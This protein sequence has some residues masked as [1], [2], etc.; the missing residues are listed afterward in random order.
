MYFGKIEKICSKIWK[1]KSAKKKRMK[2][3]GVTIN[4]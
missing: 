4:N 1:T 3:K 2:K